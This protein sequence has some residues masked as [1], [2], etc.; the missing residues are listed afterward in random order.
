V[1]K[2]K[3]TPWFPA[4]VNPAREGVYEVEPLSMQLRAFAYWNGERFGY[5]CWNYP[6]MPNPVADA[7]EM[8]E[9]STCLPAMTKWRGL[10]EQ[11]K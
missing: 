5:R 3:L 9:C 7:Y 8:R 11:P 6:D 2:Q 10:A 4:N 1:K